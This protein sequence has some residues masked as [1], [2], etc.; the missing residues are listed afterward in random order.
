MTEKKDS[1]QTNT[2]AGRQEVRFYF[3]GVHP[4]ALLIRILPKYMPAITTDNL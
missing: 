1:K 2:L 4:V 3:C